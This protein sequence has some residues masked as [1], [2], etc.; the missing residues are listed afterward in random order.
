MKEAGKLKGTEKSA[1]MLDLIAGMDADRK[2]QIEVGNAFLNKTEREGLALAL[3]AGLDAEDYIRAWEESN[4]L[5]LEY[6]SG[7]DVESKVATANRKKRKE[8]LENWL[9]RQGYT[10]AQWIAMMEAFGLE[11]EEE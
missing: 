5:T 1:E 2:V 8:E 7:K 4:R 9:N 11:T 6:P 3:N 10:N